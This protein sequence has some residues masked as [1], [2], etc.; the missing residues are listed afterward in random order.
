MLD[1][2][3]TFFKWLGTIVGMLLV[4]IISGA[5]LFWNDTQVDIKELTIKQESVAKNVLR[6]E[7]SSRE[8][9]VALKEEQRVIMER[10]E[11]NRVEQNAK[12]DKILDKID[13]LKE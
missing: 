12:L 2:D 3:R 10:I 7:E 1:E 4:L 8:A 5:F 9:D 11:I 6:V 13:A